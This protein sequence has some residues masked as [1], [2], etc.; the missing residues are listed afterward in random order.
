MKRNFF[1]L[2]A[3]KFLQG[4]FVSVGLDVVWE[5]IPKHLTDG[6]TK[7]DPT[8]LFEFCRDIIDTTKDIVAVYKPNYAFFEAYGENGLSALKSVCDY[9]R[10]L[11]EGIPIIMDAKR[12]D[13]G[14]TNNG[15]VKAMF[16]HFQVDALTVNPYFGGK[17]LRPFFDNSDKAFFVLARTSNE[18][19]DE[20]QNLKL[21]TGERL[22]ERVISN[23]E[24]NW[25]APNACLVIGATVPMELAKGRS[26]APKRIIL[27]PGVGAQGGDLEKVVH[28]GLTADADGILVNSSRAIIYASGGTDFADVA[29]RETLKLHEGILS[30]RK[31]MQEHY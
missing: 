10:L 25:N 26:L 8:V 20:F 3:A 2:I 7:G 15:T 14:N 11:D 29:R 13:I 24:N 5:N 31:E 30:L 6:K 12:A 23:I 22:Y 27:I 16:E 17:S 1:E 4:K 9:I 21:E 18:E 19:A 28:N